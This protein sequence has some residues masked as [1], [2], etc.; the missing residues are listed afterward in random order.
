VDAEPAGE[1]YRINKYHFDL[2]APASI[3][4]PEPDPAITKIFFPELFRASRAAGEF[5][6][7]VNL[8]IDIP[9]NISDEALVTPFMETVYT[10]QEKYGGF[11]L[12]PDLGDKGFNL[13]LFWGAPIAKERDIEYALNFVLELAERTRIPLRA[14]ITYRIAYTGF[15]GA[16]L[17][18][19][20]TAY[21]WGV[22]LAARL[23]EHAPKARS[24]WTKRSRAVPLNFSTWHISSDQYSF[25][26]FAENNASGSWLAERK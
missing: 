12:R 5:R 7:V 24:G 17:R 15:M 25:K 23:M 26:G 3:S 21:G 16:P 14:G 6:Q 2:P 10:L 1:C 11:F 9:I 8:F 18:E 13:L 20:Y 4:D 19:D 22:N